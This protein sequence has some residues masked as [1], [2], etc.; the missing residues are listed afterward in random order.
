[1]FDRR[2]HERQPINVISAGKRKKEKLTELALLYCKAKWRLFV[3]A[4]TPCDGFATVLTFDD[5]MPPS[6][7]LFYLRLYFWWFLR[8]SL[9]VT[10]QASSTI[11]KISCNAKQLNAQLERLMFYKD[12]CTLYHS[13]VCMC[14]VPFDITLHHPT[15]RWAISHNAT[16]FVCTLYQS[17]LRWAISRNATLFLCTLYHSTLRRAISRNATPFVCTPYSAT[18]R[19][20]I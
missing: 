19:W 1:M 14:A 20:A 7:S 3:I 4:T 6:K 13:T 10:P 8:D 15:L 17:T 2:F 5:V 11:R 18:L 9:H 16:P 12:V